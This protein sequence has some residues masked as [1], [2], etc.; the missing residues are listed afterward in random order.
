MI[1][2][3]GSCKIM[4]LAE[5]GRVENRFH[6]TN[7]DFAGRKLILIWFKAQQAVLGQSVL[8]DFVVAL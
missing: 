2:D 6:Q 1:E 5:S 7:R 4:N 8:D 3:K